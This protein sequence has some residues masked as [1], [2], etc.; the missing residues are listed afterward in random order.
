MAD[1][2]NTP[3][4]G[5]DSEAIRREVEREFEAEYGSDNR[6]DPDLDVL[7]DLESEVGL[8]EVALDQ[9]A[10]D[11]VASDDTDDLDAD[12]DGIVDDTDDQ[13]SVSDLPQ[14][15]TESYGTGLQGQP[16][17]R[18]GTYSRRGEHTIGEPDYVIT[19]G[20]VDANYDDADAVGEEAVGGTASTPDQDVVDEIGAA[21]GLEMDDRSFLRTNDM[22]EER[23]D[24]R[25]ELDP[26]SSE[27]Y[28]N[29]R[30]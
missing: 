30:D 15:F 3:D 29:R 7:E 22:L 11:T 8:R 9:A 21:V 23:D 2:S 1:L 18:A 10:F 28:Q 19:G 25:W 27:D 14:E 16:S 20:D 6:I 13:A 4:Y 5:A 17:D 26:K 12:D 24:R